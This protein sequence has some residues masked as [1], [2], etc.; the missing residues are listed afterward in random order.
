MRRVL[1]TAWNFGLPQPEGKSPNPSEAHGLGL[2][3][4]DEGMTAL[5][6]TLQSSHDEGVINDAIGLRSARP[7]GVLR[8]VLCPELSHVARY[9][10]QGPGL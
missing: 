6:S 9:Q 3:A 5:C 7:D 2:A 8:A 4:N 10:R 1:A